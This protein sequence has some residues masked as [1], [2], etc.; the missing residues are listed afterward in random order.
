MR[1]MLPFALGLCGVLSVAG[2]AGADTWKNVVVIDTNCVGDFKNKLDEHTAECAMQCEKGGYGLVTADGKYL[3]FDAAGNTKAVA[4]FKGTKKKD[5]LRGTVVGE[6]KGEV[7]E[8][9]SVSLD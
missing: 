5:H 2:A 4:A 8:V 7:V 3:K 1:H 6:L 9:K